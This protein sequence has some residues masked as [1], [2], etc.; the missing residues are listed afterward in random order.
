MT[1]A[2]PKDVPLAPP[3][4][5]FK[6]RLVDSTG[7]AFAGKDFQLW[8]GWRMATFGVTGADGV[9]E[10]DLD[11]RFEGGM[12]DVGEQVEGK[13]AA[14]WTIPLEVV[15]PAPPPPGVKIAAP[16]PPKVALTTPPPSF[17][18]D[19]ADPPPP[20]PVP[21][22]HGAEDQDGWQRYQQQKKA[23]D[24]WEGRRARQKQ[25]VQDQQQRDQAL[26]DDQQAQAAL[27][28]QYQGGD[29]GAATAP[30]DGP[31]PPMT[32]EQKQALAAAVQSARNQYHAMKV[33]LYGLAFRLRNLGYLPDADPLSFPV[34]GT[35][36]DRLVEAMRRYAWKNQLPL[37]EPA[38]LD[39]TSSTSLQQL[40]E[41]VRKEHD[42]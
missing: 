30:Q 37:V 9:V 36:R 19:E 32:D 8:W 20:M 6:M 18:T 24:D 28:Q 13:F 16:P 27:R 11:D 42:G 34:Q 1:V 15:P 31:A 7:K 33:C 5:H 2:A 25:E 40:D 17:W 41:A 10:A 14:R 12:L 3:T 4:F 22:L 21:P 39:G 35:A 38:E 29:P 23:W 26:R